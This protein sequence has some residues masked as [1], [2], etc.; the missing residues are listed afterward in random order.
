[1]GE[2]CDGIDL[3]GEDCASQGYAFG[4]LGCSDD[5]TF[6]LGSCNDVGACIEENLGSATG[7]GVASGSTDN[8]DEDLAQSCGDSGAV[9]HVLV[10]TAPSAGTWRFDTVDSAYDTTISLHADCDSAAFDCN[11]DGFPNNLDSR[12]V[13]DLAAGDVVVIAV[14][15][16]SGSTGNWVLNVNLDVPGAGDCC[17]AHGTNGCDSEAGCEATVCASNADCCDAGAAWSQDCVEIA[18]TSCASCM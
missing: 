4:E 18:N 8:E 12:L 6:G 16:Y 15:G 9:D 2:S 13:V 10:W 17:V 5:C 3:A 7:N 11:D 1:M 14:A